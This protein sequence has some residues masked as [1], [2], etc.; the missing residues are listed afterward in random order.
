V[1]SEKRLRDSNSDSEDSVDDNAPI[2][3]LVG[4]DDHDKRWKVV[5]VTDFGRED[6]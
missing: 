5:L 2:N 6:M 3:T 1:I 4:G